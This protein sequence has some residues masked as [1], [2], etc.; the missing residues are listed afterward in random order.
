M[1]AG[2]M[3]MAEQGCWLCVQGAELWVQGR[4]LWLRVADYLRAVF[5]IAAELSSLTHRAVTRAVRFSNQLPDGRTPAVPMYTAAGTKAVLHVLRPGC[6]TG[7]CSGRGVTARSRPRASRAASNTP[8]HVRA[9]RL[10]FASSTM[11]PE[12]RSA[13]WLSIVVIC[14][15]P[16]SRR[17]Q[18]REAPSLGRSTWRRHRQMKDPQCIAVGTYLLSLSHWSAICGPCS[19]KEPPCAAQ[20]AVA[21]SGERRV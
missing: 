1:G 4:W 13:I 7:W 3:A 6:Q 18:S 19:G 11:T 14:A 8:C 20:S 10:R 12:R 15:P 2:A 21:R 17:N 5:I 16:L 9:C